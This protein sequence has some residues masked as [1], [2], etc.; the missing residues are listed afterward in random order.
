LNMKTRDHLQRWDFTYLNSL[1]SDFT[2]RNN[3]G[4]AYIYKTKK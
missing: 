3:Y 4:H 1:L 2:H